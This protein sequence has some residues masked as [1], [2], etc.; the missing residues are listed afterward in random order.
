MKILMIL[1]GV[2]VD[3]LDSDPGECEHWG[4]AVG[5]AMLMEDFFNAVDRAF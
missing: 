2:N 1:R 4:W 3:T 5:V